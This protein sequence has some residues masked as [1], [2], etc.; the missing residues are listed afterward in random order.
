MK[1][2]KKR[3]RNGNNQ[4]ETRTGR[5]VIVED[6]EVNIPTREEIEECIK[7]KNNKGENGTTAELIKYGGEGITDAMHKLISMI[8]TTEEMPQSW[9]TEII[10][11][12]KK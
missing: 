9:N 6:K 2:K 12:I 5:R 4:E 3:E 1:M 7:K 8:R 10:C 11:P